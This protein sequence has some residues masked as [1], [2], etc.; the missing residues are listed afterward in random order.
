MIIGNS[1][2]LRAK[3]TWF[4]AC[5]WSKYLSNF[6]CF[7]QVIVCFFN[8]WVGRWLARFLTHWAIENEKFLAQK[9]KCTCLGQWDGSFF[10]PCYRDYLLGNCVFLSVVVMYTQAMGSKEWR[11]VNIHSLLIYKLNPVWNKNSL[12]CKLYWFYPE[13]SWWLH[14]R[15][16][17]ELLHA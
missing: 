15:N 13:L 5:P 10:W 14:V 9:E 2:C 4:P 12:D 6:A 3:K 16:T 7:E 17:Q 8:D 1:G 11:E